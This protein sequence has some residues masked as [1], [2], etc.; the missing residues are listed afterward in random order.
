MDLLSKIGCRRSVV[1]DRH[2]TPSALGMHFKGYLALVTIYPKGT[3]ALD[4]KQDG[5]TNQGWSSN[6]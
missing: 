1:E 5:H 2:A 3:K 4:P 6:S